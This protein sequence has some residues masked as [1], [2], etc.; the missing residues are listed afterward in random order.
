MNNWDLGA[1]LGEDSGRGRRFTMPIIQIK[2][3]EVRR[4]DPHKRWDGQGAVRGGV[5]GVDGILA[6]LFCMPK[7]PREVRDA[8]QLGR[9]APQLGR[10]AQSLLCQAWH[11]NCSE[12]SCRQH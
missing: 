8:Q 5:R 6:F 7:F 4:I 11:R 1:L 9:D 10:Y 12:S 2:D 3:G